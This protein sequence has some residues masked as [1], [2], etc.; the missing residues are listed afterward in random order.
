MCTRVIGMENNVAGNLIQKTHPQSRRPSVIV[1]TSCDVTF[2]V[3][4][5][6][7]TLYKEIDIFKI[8]TKYP[9]VALKIESV[10]RRTIVEPPPSFRVSHTLSSIQYLYSHSDIDSFCRSDAEYV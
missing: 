9:S 8:L 4:F 5:F 6:E 10:I 2:Y 1:V 7:N 3:V